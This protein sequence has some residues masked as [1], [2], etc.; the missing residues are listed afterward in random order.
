MIKNVA[1]PSF[2]LALA[3]TPITA[4]A[5]KLVINSNQSDPAPKQAFAKVVDEFKKQNP[6]LQVDFNSILRRFD[7]IEARVFKEQ[8]KEASLRVR[9]KGREREIPRVIE[10]AR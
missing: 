2:I 9:D 4:H 3:F 7:K 5:E 10:Q 8:G 1:S 6:D